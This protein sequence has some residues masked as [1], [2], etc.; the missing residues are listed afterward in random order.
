MGLPHSLGKPKINQLEVAVNHS[1]CSA[2]LA[3]LEKSETISVFYSHSWPKQNQ[4]SPV[5]NARP[6]RYD[7]PRIKEANC[8]DKM[9]DNFLVLCVKLHNIFC[10][11]VCRCSCRNKRYRKDPRVP[12]GGQED[13][14]RAEV[15]FRRPW[16]S[17][18][19]TESWTEVQYLSSFRW[20][21]TRGE[22]YNRSQT[23][24]S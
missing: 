12:L 7:H 18:W 23:L 17:S 4:S 6:R 15:V 2:C 21:T 19:D 14:S 1:N 20:F 16:L 13:H 3:D 22:R 9:T 8:L 10:S 5:P 24:N 11:N